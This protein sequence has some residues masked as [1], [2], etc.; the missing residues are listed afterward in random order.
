LEAVANIDVCCTA[1]LL[2][3]G[4]VQCVL[5]TGLAVYCGMGFVEGGSKTFPCLARFLE[6]E[7]KLYVKNSV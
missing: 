4:D 7:N 3:V 6:E 2:D 5:M 1:V